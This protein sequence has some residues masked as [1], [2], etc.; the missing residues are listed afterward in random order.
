MSPTELQHLLTELYTERLEL[1]L[2]HE[3]SAAV[4]GDYDINNTYQYVLNREETH[5][6]WIRQAVVDV[7]GS[8]SHDPSRPSLPAG[9]KM[10]DVAAE[11]ARL[12]AAFVERW[13]PRIERMTHARHRGMLL[14]M[15]GEMLEHKRFFDQAAEGRSDLL[16]LPMGIHKRVGQVLGK[17]WVE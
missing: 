5:V 1:L 16:G 9:A 13:R 17:R 3:A 12:N 15:L 14:V 4:M 6:S 7:G 8:I 11:D 2:R 10:R